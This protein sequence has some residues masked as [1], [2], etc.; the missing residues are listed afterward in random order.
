M[1][2]I[3]V[4]A[5]ERLNE[6]ESRNKYVQFPGANIA[7]KKWKNLIKLYYHYSQPQQ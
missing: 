7:I 6:S 3:V 1:H 2:K 4:C 5:S